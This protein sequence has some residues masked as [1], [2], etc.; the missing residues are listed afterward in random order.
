[1]TTEMHVFDNGP[2]LAEG[3]AGAVSAALSAAIDARG[4]ASIA[5]SGGSTPKAFFKALSQS[6]IDWSKVSITLVD[7]RFVR[8]GQ[9][10]FERKAGQGQPADRGRI[11]GDIRTALLSDS[12]RGGSGGNG[13]ETDRRHRIAF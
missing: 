3:L 5:V 2:A 10:S 9:R 1:M 4:T 8:A 13:N 7:E 11:G 12:N 6:T